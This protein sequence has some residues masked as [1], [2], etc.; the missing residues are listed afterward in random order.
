MSHTIGHVIGATYGIPHGITSCITL[1]P[2]VHFKAEKY[3]EDAKQ[4]AKTLPFIGKQV[5]GDPKKDA[6]LV[7]DA[8]KELVE[9]LGLKSTLSD[10]S[11]YNRS[12]CKTDL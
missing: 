6:H 9:G 10:V 3:P 12:I 2:T 8:V 4:I 5:T 11:T 1:S 7:G